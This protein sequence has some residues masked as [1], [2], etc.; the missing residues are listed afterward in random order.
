[1]NK[2][3]EMENVLALDLNLICGVR[4]RSGHEDRRESVPYITDK[5][6]DIQKTLKHNN[7]TAT[8]CISQIHNSSEK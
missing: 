4:K 5:A 8:L 7:K 1:M 3:V 2:T 6:L